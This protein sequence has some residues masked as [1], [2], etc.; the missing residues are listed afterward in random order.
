MK[1]KTL[2]CSILSLAAI[3]AMGIGANVATTPW[4]PSTAVKADD[5]FKDMT[6]KGF[7]AASDGD[8]VQVENWFNSGKGFSFEFKLADNVMK[9]MS[10][11]LYSGSTEITSNFYGFQPNEDGTDLSTNAAKIASWRGRAFLLNAEEKVYR[12]ELMFSDLVD[13]KK[14]GFEDATVDGITFL[15]N[16]GAPYQNKFLV[17][18]L[19]VINDYS[20][21]AFYHEVDTSGPDQ[22]LKY[23][24][25]TFIQI[26]NWKTSGKG[27]AL[28]FKPRENGQVVVMLNGNSA[29]GTIRGR[30]VSKYKYIYRKGGNPDVGKVFD[31]GDGWYRYEVMFSELESVNVDGVDGGT[32]TVTQLHIAWMSSGYG[33]TTS[34][35]TAIIDGYSYN[36][37]FNIDGVVTEKGY[38]AKALEEPTAP[39][40]EGNHFCGWYT[41]PEFTNKYE[42]GN[43]LTSDVSLYAK[44]EPHAYTEHCHDENEHWDACECGEKT[45][46]GVH[47]YDQEAANEEFYAAPATCMHGKEYYKSCVC[48]AKGSETFMV[49][50]KDPTV[51]VPGASTKENMTA[52]GC[53]TD[54]GYDNVVRCEEC[55]EIVSSSHVVIPASGHDYVESSWSLSEDKTTGTLH[56]VCGNDSSHTK[57]VS[58]TVTVV[59]VEPTTEKDGKATY[60]LSA[61]FE[62]KSY[63]HVIEEILPKK[64]PEPEPKKDGGCG[65]AI[66]GCSAAAIVGLVGL[67]VVAIKR[68]EK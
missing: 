16:W 40:K 5:G 32:F 60:T 24:E 23:A 45:N 7:W 57:D 64:D 49:G 34:G 11:K 12:Y 3:G 46:V 22:Y 53:E 30:D 62:G 52:P 33:I 27:F 17:R 37:S 9:E 43:P 20:D 38:T 48:G 28:H 50:E 26:E 13:K 10:V 31:I 54:G 21:E 14:A 18:D 61:N 1:K 2:I 19:K 68:K 44:F 47:V 51:H 4:T 39:S 58:A 36:Y 65:G 41:E 55:H 56:L 67:G 63:S 25:H 59:V 8:F 6:E 66:V 29:D 15:W 35:R 42:F